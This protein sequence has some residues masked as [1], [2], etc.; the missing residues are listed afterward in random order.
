MLISLSEHTDISSSGSYF[1][2]PSML[3]LSI[4]TRYSRHNSTKSNQRYIVPK[5]YDHFI[6]AYTTQH[7]ISLVLQLDNPSTSAEQ[8]PS[9]SFDLGH[10]LFLF[11]LYTCIPQKRLYRSMGSTLSAG[12]KQGSCWA[13]VSSRLIESHLNARTNN[14]QHHSREFTVG[15][16]HST[17]AETITIFNNVSSIK[18]TTKTERLIRGR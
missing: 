8:K 1:F 17:T 9:L 14:C 15:G 6:I 12:R 5:Q 4:A 13:Q 10:V 3:S 7:Y 16:L 11:L 2:G 18:K